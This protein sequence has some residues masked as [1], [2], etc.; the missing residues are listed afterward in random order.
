MN[1]R[2]LGLLLLLLFPYVS[3]ASVSD[4]QLIRVYNKL[5]NVNGIKNYPRLAIDRNLTVAP[6]GK[7]YRK[8]NLI[9]ITQTLLNIADEDTIATTLGHELAHAK[10]K[11]E[12]TSL[13]SSKASRKQ[14]SKADSEGKKLTERAK[15]NVCRGFKWIYKMHIK[16]E[17]YHPDSDIRNKALGC[18]KKGV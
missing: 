13:T 10:Y 15:Y 2:L 14:E 6:N 9:V 7:Y 4:M 16:G 12:I 1:R 18:N 5:C 3:Y 8:E 11:H 17:Y